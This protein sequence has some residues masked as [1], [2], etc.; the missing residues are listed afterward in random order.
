MMQIFFFSLL[1]KCM[2]FY[3]RSF[4]K[5]HAFTSNL[6]LVYLQVICNFRPYLQLIEV[7]QSPSSLLKAFD[8]V[9]EL[10]VYSCKHK[11]LGG[12][13]L[14]SKGEGSKAQ[15]MS[16]TLGSDAETLT[17]FL[18][19]NTLTLPNQVKKGKRRLQGSWVV[20]GRDIL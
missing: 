9:L 6:S 10:F 5:K 19:W 15:G 11:S 16:S 2:L 7:F 3:N 4:L 17:V 13:D 1:F 18:G 14:F 8:L 20:G 12:S